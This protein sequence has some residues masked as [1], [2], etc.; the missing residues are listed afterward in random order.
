[1]RYALVV[2][3]R[4]GSKSSCDESLKVG[5]T[6]IYL[7]FYL[8]IKNNFVKKKKNLKGIDHF[9]DNIQS[10]LWRSIS[11]HLL[12][13]CQNTTV[14]CIIRSLS[15]PVCC[16]RFFVPPQTDNCWGNTDTRW[17][18]RHDTIG[19]QSLLEAETEKQKKSLILVS[20][21][22]SRYLIDM[23]IIEYFKQYR[24][25]VAGSQR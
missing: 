24:A 16:T 3:C 1:M 11:L 10:L 4:A 2:P 8:C 7:Q 15:L 14:V 19:W 25:L 5:H 20:V 13:S 6:L 23:L 17:Y 18:Q 9:I 21:L 12:P 22:I